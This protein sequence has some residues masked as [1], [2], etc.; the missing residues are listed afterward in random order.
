MADADSNEQSQE[1][2]DL[3]NDSADSVLDVKDVD[4]GSDLMLEAAAE[5]WTSTI[6]GVLWII[7]PCLFGALIV[8]W[9]IEG[10]RG[11]RNFIPFTFLSASHA[12][13]E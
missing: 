11:P 10:L 4:L 8:G 7:L 13:G 5:F 1:S 2:E 12:R 3:S 6:S 9:W